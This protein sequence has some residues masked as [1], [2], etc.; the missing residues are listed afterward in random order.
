VLLAALHAASR[1]AGWPRLAR[2]P[3]GGPRICEDLGFELP[4]ALQQELRRPFAPQEVDVA[5]RSLGLES[6]ATVA[7]GSAPL[8]V[9]L[10]GP[11][12][13][14]KSSVA[15]AAAEGLGI[16]R[17]PPDGGRAPGSVG[18]LDAV[19]VDGDA[20]RAAHRGFQAVARDGR[21]RHCTW[22]EAYPS[23]RSALRKQKQALL[24]LAVKKRLNL[25][26]PHT[27]QVRGECWDVLD[28][29]RRRGYVNH[30]VLVLGHKKTIRMRGEL[31]AKTTGKRYAP[32]EWDVS[33]RNGLGMVSRA[34]GHAELVWT[35]PRPTWLVRRGRAD[36]V[37]AAVAAATAFGRRPTAPLEP[38]QALHQEA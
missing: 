26:I 2:R 34:N 16:A 22:R 13:A 32:Q 37:L 4:E 27:C 15:E 12:A 28:D 20:F 8:A 14:G 31:R 21:A 38:Q 7:K 36:H 33:L 10:V 24:H 11:S 23:L 3:L 1:A 9:W 6:A 25:L 35:T 18:R 29:L 17:R 5:H 30:V 19:S